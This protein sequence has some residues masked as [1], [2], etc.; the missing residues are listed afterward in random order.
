MSKVL[1]FN[2]EYPQSEDAVTLVFNDDFPIESVFIG[3]THPLSSY[4]INRKEQSNYHNFEYVLSGKGE[5][6]IDGKK[7]PLSSGDAFVL[8][9][10]NVHNFRSD[11]RDPL[12][13]IWISLKSDYLDK[14][15]ESFKVKSGVY[16]VNVEKNFLAIFNVARAETTPQNKFFTIA[17]N[18]HQIITTISKS[19]LTTND[20]VFN[21]IK[22]E[23]LSSVYT[24]R[25]LDEIASKLFMSRSNLIRIFKK[26]TGITPY[27]FLLNEK[28]SVAST[29]LSSTDMTVKAVSDLLCFTDEHYFS[30][31][32]KQKTG[33][34]PTEFRN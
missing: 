34:T 26:N 14:M 9:K 13:K 21:S 19:I 8:S 22:N 31:L 10:V 1:D 29:L 6:I 28:L 11:K 32:F 20:S 12:K 7:M 33:K 23:L 30:F 3:I 27:A 5:I 16:K 25:S 15:I 4:Q 17:D 2:I 24:K 18:L